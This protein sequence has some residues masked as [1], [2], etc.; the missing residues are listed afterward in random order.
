MANGTYTPL[1]INTA[2]GMLNNQGIKSLPSALTAA[3]AAYNGKTVIANWLAAVNA[4]QAQS[5]KTTS[6]LDLLLSIGSGTIPALGNSIP[7]P[8]LGNFPNLDREYFPSQSD[9]STL[10]PYGFADLVQQTGN[11]YLGIANDTQDLSR[12]CQGFIA[13]QSFV[14]L[15]NAFINST[16]NAATYLGPTFTNMNN[17]VTNSLTSLVNNTP[18]SI[19]ALAT[20]LTNQGLLVDTKTLNLYGTPAALLAQLSKEAKIVGSTLPAVK[21]KLLDTGLTTVDIANLV[22]LNVQ[23]FDNV[24]GLTANEFDKL[25]RLAYQAM[26]TVTGSDLQDVLDTLAVT[27]PN[28]ATMAD[29]LD[30][31][32]VFPNSYLALTTPTPTVPQAIYQPNGAV[33]MNLAPTVNAFV[34][35]PSGCDQ[36]AKIIPPDQAV[37]NKAL[38]SS[39]QQIADIANTTWPK[40]SAAIQQSSRT[41]W[42]PSRPWLENTV[43]A[44]APA[45]PASTLAVPLAVLSPD[46]VFYRAIDDV[47]AGTNITDTNYWEPV[48][49]SGPEFAINTM[50]G[51]DQ[52][53]ALTNPVAAAT[54]SYVDTAVATGSGPDGNI[55]ICDV[56]GTAIDYHDL[57]ALF[58]TVSSGIQT[59]QDAGALAT[60]NTAYANISVA[61]SDAAVLTQISNAESAIATLATNPSY[62]ATVNAINLAWVAIATYLNRE[63]TYQIKAGV[64]YFALIGGEQSSVLSF[65]QLL[66][67][68]GRDTTDCGAMDFLLQVADTTVL[69][70]QA[71]VGSLR[72]AQTQQQLAAASM[73]GSDIKPSTELPVVPQRS[74]PVA[75]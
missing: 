65:C 33:N 55:T 56:L 26:T 22:N 73:L 71:L 17:L 43:V 29:L 9:A 38:Q 62:T 66:N 46:T 39:L 64:D 53:N 44:L 57:A 16:H 36:L 11:A 27:T 10:D 31:T 2:A 75:N 54:T 58:A 59:L 45:D 5:Y 41:P 7:T 48:A 13:V 50:T 70:G 63:K 49:V 72:E 25:Q 14:G 60:I 74:V 3:I 40:L 30:P 24:N 20:D 47:P 37:A 18:G 68:Y 51:L 69:S 52:I 8:P 12:F 19:T 21:D 67:Q 1:Q 42:T 6:T 61:L 15:T 32:V 35:A 28:V 34:P 23:S 4:Y